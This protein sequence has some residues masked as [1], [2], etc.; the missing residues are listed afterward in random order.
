MP[1]LRQQLETGL[2]GRYRIERQL[3]RGGTATVFLAYDSQ[4]QRSVAI[5][6]LDPELAALMGP[7][8]FLREIKIAQR[9]QHR[10]IIPL[11]ESG[12]T[13]GLLYY[14]MPVADGGS[15]RGRLVREKQLPLSDVLEIERQVSSALS[16]AHAQGVIHRDIKPENI[17]MWDNRAVIADFGIARAMTEV[18]D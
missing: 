1:D 6:V 7:A 9:L 4:D 18:Q 11:Y 16:Y 2:A 14:V 3:G 10:H 17:L 13:G 8:R 5:K 12:E 15:L